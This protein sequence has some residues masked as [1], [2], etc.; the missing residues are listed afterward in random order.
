MKKR[1]KAKKGPLYRAAWVG[2]KVICA[3]CDQEVGIQPASAL[4]SEAHPAPIRLSKE[5]ILEIYGV[6][7]A[8]FMPENRMRC[9]GCN[10]ATKPSKMYVLRPVENTELRGPLCTGCLGWTLLHLPDQ[11]DPEVWA[12]GTSKRA[13]EKIEAVEVPKKKKVKRRVVDLDTLF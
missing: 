5:E 8:A 10:K 2:P 11:Y 13:R 6:V 9:R 4:H 12:V 3:C 1:V 7:R